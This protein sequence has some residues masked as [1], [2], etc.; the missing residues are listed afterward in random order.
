MEASRHTCLKLDIGPDSGPVFVKGTW[1][2]SHFELLI[3]DGLNAWSC[4]GSEEEVKDRAFQWDQSVSEYIQLAERYL[5]F[6]HPE[7]VYGFNDAANG[8]KRLS[9]TFEREGTKLEWRWKCRPSSNSKQST[10]LILDFLMD[11]NIRLSEE[12]VKKTQLSEKLKEEAE[13]CL[14]Q[15]EKFCSEKAEFETAVYEKFLR[16]LNSKKAKLRELRDRLSKQ[17]ASGKL[18]EE[19]EEVSTDKTE[20]FDER[21]DDEKGED[22]LSKD[23][24]S[25]S[26]NILASRPHGRKRK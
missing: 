6:Q 26:K 11:S 13:K 10:A 16:V 21:S 8:H 7:S 15:S 25:S 4:N 22:E 23:L 2:N 3:T 9:W 17:G 5:G 24:P 18:E 12:V 1:Y 14:A 19:D 20:S